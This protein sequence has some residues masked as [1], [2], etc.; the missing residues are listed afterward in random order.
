MQ[1]LWTGSFLEKF[2]INNF[3]YNLIKNI[4]IIYKTEVLHGFFDFN[5]LQSVA[6]SPPVK[7]K[8]TNVDWLH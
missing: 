5:C 8:Q 3:Y 4:I 6:L 1:N 2:Y 7:I